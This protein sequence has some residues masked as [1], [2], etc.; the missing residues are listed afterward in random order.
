MHLTE[1][2][3]V[4]HY[5]GDAD[6]SVSAELH[7]TSCERCREEFERLRRVLSLIDAQEAAE[8]AAGFEQKVW[9]RLEPQLRPRVAAPLSRRF[10]GSW[11]SY[12]GGIAAMLLISFVMGRLSRG[13]ETPAA[14]P[15]ANNAMERIL[16]VAVVDH[17]DQSEMM[18]ME[19]MNE[20]V[21]APTLNGDGGQS[22]ARELVAANRL[23]RR[24]AVQAGDAAVSDVLDE[25]ERVLLEIANT[26]HGDSAQDVE[27]LRARID[28]RGL[29]FR[30][31]V[32]HSEM[33]QRQRQEFVPGSTS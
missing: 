6:E 14:P 3:L 28:T 31:R 23:Y 30:V 10:V 25:L 19:L 24:S 21:G 20:D 7:I 18:L 27:A 33:R 4:L 11:W 22:R 12:A 32:V 1:E 26:S 16:V 29:L 8:P 15:G 5:Y 9:A 17:L 2:A 13:G